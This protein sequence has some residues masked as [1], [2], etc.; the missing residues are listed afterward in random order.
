M[1]KRHEKGSQRNTRR[2]MLRMAALG[3]GAIVL[4]AC[5]GLPGLAP[6]A[7]PIVFEAPGSS[8]AE[9]PTIAAPPADPQQVA[10]TAPPVVGE[11]KLELRLDFWIPAARAAVED[12]ER[13]NS[14]IKVVFAAGDF[15]QIQRTAAA[16]LANPDSAADLCA[17]SDAWFG[18]FIAANGLLDLNDPPFDANTLADQFVAPIWQQANIQGRQLAIPWLAYPTG[19]FYRA[20]VLKK[21][22]FDAEPQALTQQLKRWDDLIDLGVALKK[23]QD[24][25]ILLADAPEVF[26]TAVAQAGNLI[27]DNQVL[28]EELAIR[29]AELALRARTEGI[30]ANLQQNNTALADFRAGRIISIIGGL[31]FAQFIG[32]QFGQATPEWRFISPPEGSGSTGSV[33]LGIPQASKHK[34]E[35]WALIKHL[36]ASIDG[37]NVALKAGSGLPVFTQ[38]WLDPIYEQTT[39]LFGDQKLLKIGNELSQQL[40]PS[41]F[42]PYDRDLR[43]VLETELFQILF[44]KKDP[45][46]AMQDAEK[47]MIRKGEGLR[48]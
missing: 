12:F 8:T 30:D 43:E 14:D 24:D 17:I 32:E 39:P 34:E 28:I 41:T 26:W 10:A 37:Q 25:L 11:S 6:T 33:Y 20:D 45:A 36:S 3:G 38:A 40:K 16:T 15:D 48:A 7:T 21:A 4:N 42:S 19:M 46:K 35:A 29:P 31:Q 2:Q 13:Q 27:K 18:A 47:A 23:K 1:D 44:A 9:Q 5:G 22:G